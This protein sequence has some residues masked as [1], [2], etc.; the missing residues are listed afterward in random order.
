METK[1]AGMKGQEFK[2]TTTKSPRIERLE[3]RKARLEAFLAREPVGANTPELLSHKLEL[4]AINR[5]LA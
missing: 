1:Q 4:L 3:A 5:R 2:V